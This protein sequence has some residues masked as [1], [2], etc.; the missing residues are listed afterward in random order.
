M[1]KKLFTRT[2]TQLIQMEVCCFFLLVGFFS[3]SCH[4]L[5]GKSHCVKVLGN[6]KLQWDDWPCP[7]QTFF[8]C[9]TGGPGKI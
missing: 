4:I 9:E 8:I 5:G 7:Y 6:V 1:E 2:G 3:F